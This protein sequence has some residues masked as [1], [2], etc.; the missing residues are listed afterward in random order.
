MLMTRQASGVAPGEA[1]IS[2][3]RRRSFLFSAAFDLPYLKLLFYPSV[4]RRQTLIV[5]L[6]KLSR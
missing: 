6:S 1:V 5:Q 3:R 4:L 2:E